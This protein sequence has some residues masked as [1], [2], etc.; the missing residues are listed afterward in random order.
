M[1]LLPLQMRGAFRAGRRANQL[2]LYQK[3]I[4]N[5]LISTVFYATNL[6]IST[7]M[8]IISFEDFK[9]CEMRIGK[10][11][12]AE[13]MEGSDKL[14]KI[15]FDF[16]GP[17]PVQILSGIAK[18]YNPDDLVGKS[19]PVIVNLEPREMMGHASNGMMLCAILDEK[20]VLLH[21]DKD[22][23]PGSLIR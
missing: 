4:V 15:M 1:V 21:P 16:G 5:V 6:L 11:L 8:D 9:K 14:L 2:L 13:K 22:V 20:P 17:E 3:R 23:P 19:V 7:Y 12:S 10:I 18:S